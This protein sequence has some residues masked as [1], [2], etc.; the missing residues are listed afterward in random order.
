MTP[1]QTSVLSP[2]LGLKGSRPGLRAKEPPVHIS[3]ILLVT[4]AG[5]TATR[6][7][8]TATTVTQNVGEEC[9]RKKR[10]TKSPAGSAPRG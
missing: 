5:E 3:A 7:N 4:V 9:G 1:N 10:E 6:H 8:A 2:S